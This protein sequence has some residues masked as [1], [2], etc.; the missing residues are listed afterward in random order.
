MD[1]PSANQRLAGGGDLA[2]GEMQAVMRKIMSGEATDAQIG[3]FLT[4][5]MIKGE[6]VEE[7]TG[8]AII[9]RELSAEVTTKRD[10]VVDCVGTG[11]DGA[12]LL[13][14]STASAIVAAVAGLAMAKHGN[15]AATGNS[16]S[17]DLLE[18]AGV[19]IGIS[20]EQV[21]Y[22]IDGCG[23]GFMFAPTH[24][25]AMRFA[26][27]PR[28]EIGIRTVFNLLGPLTN[29]AKARF[30]LAGVFSQNLV[31]PI[32]EVYAEL[33]SEHTLVVCSDDGLDEISV[34]APTRVAEYRHGKFSEYEIRPEQFG[35]TRS[36][37]DGLVVGDARESLDKIRSVLAGEKGAAYDIVAM[38]AGATIYAGEQAGSL[39]EGMDMARSILDSGQGNAKLDQLAA[40]SNSFQ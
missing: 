25:S 30:Q 14:V 21:G 23:I 15:R 27:G 36:S 28:K 11:G 33:G 24:H 12:R 35:F 7:I 26:I 9:M 38:N 22:C 8:A 1:L 5:L 4:A 40:L 37:L 6:T 31:R 2:R 17:A 3:A 39:P 10:N 32:A 20:A 18:A 13:N 16:G 19:N 34:A 29:P